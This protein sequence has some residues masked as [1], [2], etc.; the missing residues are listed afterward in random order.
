MRQRSAYRF[1]IF[2]PRNHP[3][4]ADELLCRPPCPGKA[5]RH[6]RRRRRS[7]DHKFFWSTRP[8]LHYVRAFAQSTG[9]PCHTP[10]PSQTELVLTLFVLRNNEAMDLLCLRKNTQPRL[11]RLMLFARSFHRESHFAL[12]GCSPYAHRLHHFVL[13]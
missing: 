6:R 10:W 8:G 4:S 3:H 2:P 11:Q 7:V 13:V 12:F 1:Q 5:I 9:S